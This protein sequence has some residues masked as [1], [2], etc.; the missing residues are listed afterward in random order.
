LEFALN[1]SLI[2]PFLP[3]C[4]QSV[5][6]WFRIS[7]PTIGSACQANVKSSRFLL[8]RECW[9]IFWNPSA[10]F[11][12]RFHFLSTELNMMGKDLLFFPIKFF[13]ESHRYWMRNV[14]KT[15]RLSFSSIDRCESA[16]DGIRHLI[17]YRVVG[18]YHLLYS[19]I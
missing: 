12:F 3:L 16:L 1:R 11:D 14:M 15:L 5:C 18:L 10:Y 6:R 4:W 7:S 19:V 9:N 2:S 17:I 13:W 8:I